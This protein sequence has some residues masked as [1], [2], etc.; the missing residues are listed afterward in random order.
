MEHFD[1]F[2]FLSDCKKFVKNLEESMKSMQLY[3][4][5]RLEQIP[6]D[7]EKSVSLVNSAEQYMFDQV[8]AGQQLPEVTEKTVFFST[9]RS[10]TSDSQGRYF[11]NVLTVVQHGDFK[12]TKIG[13]PVQ[14]PDVAVKR[15]F[16]QTPEDYP[17]KAQG[18]AVKS[19]SVVKECFPDDVP[20]AWDWAFNDKFGHHS[21]RSEGIKCIQFA[22]MALYAHWYYSKGNNLAL[23]STQLPLFVDWVDSE[24]KTFFGDA[25]NFTHIVAEGQ[26]S[27]TW[28]ASIAS[29]QNKGV[30]ILNNQSQIS[31]PNGSVVLIFSDS[32]LGC[33]S[34]P[35]STVNSFKQLGYA[36]EGQVI[37]NCGCKTMADYTETSFKKLCL[38]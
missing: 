29:K 11:E 14:M 34:E 31:L 3:E 20:D 28:A 8:K 21:F 2:V 24:I 19:S 16:E 6:I 35:S 22:V 13:R 15:A 12:F 18:W 27:Q 5:G 9:K 36:V 38:F 32:S 25:L 30:V 1:K 26:I 4:P 23:S 17:F 37:F 7:F 33:S 10:I